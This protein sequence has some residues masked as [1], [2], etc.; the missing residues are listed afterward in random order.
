MFVLLLIV[1]YNLNWA[2]NC[3]HILVE[4][5]TIMKVKILEVESLRPFNLS[6][7]TGKRLERSK[8]TRVRPA[9]LRWRRW[10][11]S[12]AGSPGIRS[13]P[14]GSA[15]LRSWAW[16]WSGPTAAPRLRRPWSTRWRCGRCAPRPGEPG[17]PREPGEHEQRAA[18]TNGWKTGF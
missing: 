8:F 12:C 13:E 9:H 16:R 15:C 3:L 5:Q 4:G 7:S 10:A 17:E 2:V 18:S 1:L 6:G 11:R 14:R